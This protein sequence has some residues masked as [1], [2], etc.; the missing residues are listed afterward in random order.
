MSPRVVVIGD[1]MLDVIVR[2]LSIM[3]PTSDTPSSVRISRGGSAANLAVALG[4]R[5]DVRYVGAVGDDES[6]AMFARELD[7]AGVTPQLQVFAGS[8]GVVVALVNDD[9]QRAMLTD[10]GVNSQLSLEGVLNVLADEFDHL[11]VSGYTVLDDATRHVASAALEVAR[12]RGSSTSVDVCSVGPLAR[13]GPEEFLTAI[14]R[15]TMLFA[16]EEESLLLAGVGDVD[17]AS[18]RLGDVAQEVVITLGDRG[19]MVRRGGELWTSDSKDVA[20]VDTTG[21]GDAAAGA[22]LAGRLDG[23]ACAVALALAM[24][25]AA[26]VVGGLGARG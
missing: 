20:V 8:T 22:Y 4:E 10:R 13:L 7:E 14:G 26:T 9:G 21:A 17:R 6:G 12:S 24:T 25:S 18:E 3:A 5:H 2:P 16:N 19:A 11:H 1:A 15:V 23:I